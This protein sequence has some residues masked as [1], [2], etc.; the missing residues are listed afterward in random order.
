MS[1]KKIMEL[2][3]DGFPHV[4]L[5]DGGRPLAVYLEKANL[6]YHIT[7][8]ILQISN[9]TY[10]RDQQNQ[11]RDST[12]PLSF[13]LLESAVE[14]LCGDPRINRPRF[15]TIIPSVIQGGALLICA[16][17]AETFPRFTEA[18][19]AKHEHSDQTLADMVVTIVFVVGSFATAYPAS[20]G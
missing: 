5:G 11:F 7:N 20:I 18:F 17:T 15:R 16:N 1:L 14:L 6:V 13:S 3:S 4:G 12:Y 8:V 2:L 19:R 10:L 9:R